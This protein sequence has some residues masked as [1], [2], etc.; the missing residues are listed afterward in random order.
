MTENLKTDVKNIFQPLKRRFE[1]SGAVEFVREDSISTNKVADIQFN[2]EGLKNK[3]TEVL[4][5]LENIR[6]DRDNSFLYRNKLFLGVNSREGMLADID[7]YSVEYETLQETKQEYERKLEKIDLMLSSI[8]VELNDAAEKEGIDTDFLIQKKMVFEKEKF[9]LEKSISDFNEFLIDLSNKVKDISS[10]L[11]EIENYTTNDIEVSD[12][13]IKS[14]NE[15]QENLYGILVG[16]EAELK[17]QQGLLADS[18]LSIEK[19]QSYSDMTI[20]N[21]EN[22][23]IIS[24]LASPSQSVSVTTVLNYLRY[25]FAFNAT[26]IS[27]IILRDKPEMDVYTAQAL[28]VKLTFIKNFGIYLNQ[29]FSVVDFTDNRIAKKILIVKD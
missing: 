25:Y 4:N 22:S 21:V 10:N 18:S 7:K 20:A 14:L 8:E 3:I 15:E 23:A 24:H 6:K 29:F 28:A 16:L 26:Q 17:H 19:S 13:K 5:K 2:V 12:S 11:S 1:Q 27:N 9:S